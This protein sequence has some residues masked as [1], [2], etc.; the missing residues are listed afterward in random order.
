MHSCRTEYAH[1][2]ALLGIGFS[3]ASRKLQRGNMHFRCHGPFATPVGSGAR[4]VCTKLD[5]A[6]MKSSL[7]EQLW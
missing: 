3:L 1:E 5:I 2:E 7:H 4:N 6:L